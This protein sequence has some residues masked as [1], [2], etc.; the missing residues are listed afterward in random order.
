MIF[1]SDKL[2]NEI[3]DT[4]PL[5][6][7]IERL[8]EFQNDNRMMFTYFN[9]GSVG[10]DYIENLLN[11]ESNIIAYYCKG[12]G[13]EGDASLT[14]D[15]LSL[16]IP[17][18]EESIIPCSEESLIPSS[19]EKEGSGI[20]SIRS[21]VS[22]MIY[23]KQ[24]KKNSDTIFYYIMLISTEPECRGKGYATALLDGFISRVREETKQST[25]KVKI[26]LSS[27]DEVV[28]Y[29]Q[30]YGFEVVDC[31]FDNY[32]FFKLFEKH[33]PDKMCTIMEFSIS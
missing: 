31:S 23:S 9:Y 1:F 29:Y 15:G 11:H 2:K 26:V 6:Q 33:D 24:N 10:I 18:S 5:D 22:C 19:E 14:A 27:L 17:C 20:F 32:P 3:I 16:M 28:S 30:M 13:R 25:K 7:I 8:E 21:C 12:T 4:T